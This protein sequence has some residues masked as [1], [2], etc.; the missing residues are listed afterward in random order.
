[1]KKIILCSVLFALISCS[2][3]SEQQNN[4]I[5]DLSKIETSKFK[6][7]QGNF[8]MTP[9]E[10]QYIITMK[11]GTISKGLAIKSVT[12]KENYKKT[13][14][15][16]NAKALNEFKTNKSLGLGFVSN[17]I[18]KAFNYALEGFVAKDVTTN[19]LQELKM[20]PNVKS[21]EQDYFV[22]L[23]KPNNPGNGGG[24][25][26]GS[27]APQETPWGIT[28]VGGFGD[29]TG[30]TAWVIDTG[31]DLDHPDLNVDVAR[32]VSY[33]GDNNPDDGNGHGTHVAGTIAAIDNGIGVV[34]VAAGANVV[35]LKVLG[36][37]GSGDFSWTVQALD[38]VRS[39]AN[40]GD[41]V[42][43][44]L[45]PSSPFIHDATDQATLNLAQTGVRIA[46]AAGNSYD[47]A[48]LYTPAHNNHQNIY[49]ISA[50]AEGDYWAYFSNYGTSVDYAAPGYDVKSTWLSGS[51]NTISGT[52]MASPHAAG[53]LLLGNP[54]SDGT[55]LPAYW[56]YVRR[57]G[58]RLTGNYGGED[59][60]SLSI[61]RYDED[62]NDD[63]I[64]H[65]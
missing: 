53:I 60:Y 3:D 30:K 64:M 14:A 56:E 21:I 29:G 55:V 59:I 11:P 19:E 40:S 47:N 44:S 25:S 35:A 18:T 65:R 45:G 62:G 4:E 52:S 28:R 16:E 8:S 33:T 31:I 7:D 32:S 23:K 1:M 13:Y 38:Y 5:Q 27:D 15:L 12:T 2:N 24:D 34:G 26:G 49:T 22:V 58:G 50:I 61:Y 43:M 51:Y 42:N 41:V 36:N 63:P 17:K 39:V 9:I 57:G 48:N 37:D 54:T 10:G 46:I 20:N 6:I